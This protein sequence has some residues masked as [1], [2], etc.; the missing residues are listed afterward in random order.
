MD[1]TFKAKVAPYVIML[2]DPI[3]GNHVG[4][5][6]VPTTTEL[7]PFKSTASAFNELIK[8]DPSLGDMVL[9]GFVPEVFLIDASSTELAEEVIP[10]VV[11]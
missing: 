6:V 10:N 8:Q 5:R 7:I 9:V 1:N 4:I 11:C 2:V 3:T